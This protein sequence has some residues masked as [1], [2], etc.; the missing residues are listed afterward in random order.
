MD[1]YYSTAGHRKM[2]AILEQS[3]GRTITAA[4][5]ADELAA[6]DSAVNITTVYRFLDRLESE[7]R[8]L[9]YA[10]ERGRQAVYQYIEPGEDCTAHL[11]LKCTRCGRLQHLDC[12]FMDEIATH[13][14]EEH[15]FSLQCRSSILYG[16]CSECQKSAE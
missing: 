13:I 11:H 10:P 9:S 8:V 14:Q 3:K 7:G 4:Q 5:I 6:A 15:G 12:S 2:L 1:R 16:L